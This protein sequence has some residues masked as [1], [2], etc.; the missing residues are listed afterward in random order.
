MNNQHSPASAQAPVTPPS[1]PDL[2]NNM[3]TLLTNSMVTKTF[4]IIVLVLVL[5][6]PEQRDD[7]SLCICTPVSDEETRNDH[8]RGQRGRPAAVSSG[9][10]GLAK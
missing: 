7:H 2:H 1:T 9:L 5:H 4:D 8:W 10:R 3:L 6:F